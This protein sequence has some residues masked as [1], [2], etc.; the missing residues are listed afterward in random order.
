MMI[1]DELLEALIAI[2]H[3]ARSHRRFTEARYLFERF[4]LLFPDR[5]FPHVGIGIIEIDCGRYE[6]ATQQFK[7]ALTRAPDH[8]VVRAWLGVS[9]LFARKYAAGTAT[10]LSIPEDAEPAALKLAAAFLG[11]RQCAVYRRELPEPVAALTSTLDQ[12]ISQGSKKSW[13]RN[14]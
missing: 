13:R 2:A 6:S 9:Q 14:R 8:H 11:F 10:L 1:N 5:A 4:A 7:E 3:H 12:L